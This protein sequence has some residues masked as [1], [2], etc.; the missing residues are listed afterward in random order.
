MNC[1]ESI[2]R[3]ATQNKPGWVRIDCNARGATS[4]ISKPRWCIRLGNTVNCN[5]EIL[6]NLK[7]RDYMEEV[8]D[9]YQIKDYMINT[10]ENK[11][12]YSFELVLTEDV[13]QSFYNSI[14]PNDNLNNN[15]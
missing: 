10:I 8:M 1:T 5:G 12:E 7:I 2:L 15:Q 4:N 9:K 11:Y 13:Y 6:K 14:N 3:N